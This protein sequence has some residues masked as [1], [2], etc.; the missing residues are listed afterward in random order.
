MGRKDVRIRLAGR[1]AVGVALLGAG[2]CTPTL[3]ILGVY[4]PAWLVSAVIGLVVAYVGVWLLARRPALRSFARSGALFCSLTV[5][6]GMLTWW[7][8]FSRF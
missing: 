5:T 6:V 3:N 1:C 8:L 4:F 2:A 7:L